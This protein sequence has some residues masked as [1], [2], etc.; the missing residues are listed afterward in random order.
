[1]NSVGLST[2]PTIRLHPGERIIREGTPLDRMQWP[3][4]LATAL[5]VSIGV[6][7]APLA[8]LA[9]WLTRRWL[10]W[11]RWWITN[12]RLVVRTGLFGWKIQS[13]PLD[14]VVDVTIGASWWDRLWRLE[15]IKVRD[16][17][18]EVGSNGV[19]P[20]LRLMAVPNAQEVADQILTTAPRLEPQTGEMA[21]VIDLL[22]T[23]VAKAG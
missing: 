8:L 6:V 19:S 11:H 4:S 7:T 13:V 9:P 23:L 18:G 10:G 21:E 2:R 14:R 20:S 5:I 17:T 1:M 22:K 16:M 3:V 12:Q 15:H